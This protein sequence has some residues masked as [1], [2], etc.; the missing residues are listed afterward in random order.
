MTVTDNE[1]SILRQSL[2]VMWIPPQS[3]PAAISTLDSL[4]KKKMM[5]PASR[6]FPNAPAGALCITERGAKAIGYA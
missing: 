2:D 3:N 4:S 5:E 6:Q 1:R